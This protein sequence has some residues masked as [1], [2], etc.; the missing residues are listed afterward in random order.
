[1]IHAFA[2]KLIGLPALRIMSMGGG[3][4]RSFCFYVP[5]ANNNKC[6]QSR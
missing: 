4:E 5:I 6:P 3:A 2:S 1:M